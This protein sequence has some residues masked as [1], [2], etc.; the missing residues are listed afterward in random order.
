MRF[1]G[2]NISLNRFIIILLLLPW[3][4]GGSIAATDIGD[5]TVIAS[6]GDYA[7]NRSILLRNSTLMTPCIIIM[8][9]DVVFD[10]RGYVIDS[11]GYQTGVSTN[12]TDNLTIR[13]I[14]LTNFSTGLSLMSTTN[15]TVNNITVS[16]NR[17]AGVELISSRANNLT[18]NAITLNMNGLV[19]RN[20]N[21]NWFAGNNI[22][23]NGNAT[24]LSES[25]NYNRFSNNTALSNTY[26]SFEISNSIGGSNRIEYLF[27]DP[28][29]SLWGTDIIVKS[30]SS[31]A[32]PPAGQRSLNKYVRV[33]DE[34]T[35]ASFMYFYVHYTDAEV[36][37]LNESKLRMWKYNGTSWS[38][39]SGTNGVDV[40]NNFVYAN[41]T[42]SGIFAPM[43]APGPEI[44]LA[45]LGVLLAVRIRRR[46]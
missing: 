21:Y 41:I 46:T 42:G 45:A 35:G 43:A 8:A 25:S 16:H 3:L 27:M 11:E 33:F 10:G 20:S 17:R 5:C 30:V 6:P 7:L 15:S 37:G 19:L 2:S 34:G 12:F 9:S 38:E 39:W 44:A 22:D 1:I 13:N 40:N 31:P 4:S 26:T 24:M 28:V 29:V 36:A 32:P 23:R 18:Y 14:R